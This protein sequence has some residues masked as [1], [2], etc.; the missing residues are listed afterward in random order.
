[1]RILITGAHGQLG[2]ELKRCLETMRAEIGPIPSEYEAADITYT[3]A[4]TLDIT[5]ARAVDAAIDAGNY[6]L[7]INCAAMTNVDG[8]E[9]AP[10][11][12]AR[13]NADAAEYLARAAARNNAKLVQV[14]TDYVFSGTEPG[15]RTETDTTGP[16][17]VYGKTKLA[18]E[19]AA[20][21]AND[22]TFVVRTAWLYGY[23][24]KNFVRTMAGLGKKL[25]RV[26]VVDDQLGNPTSANDLAYEILKIALTDNYGIYH[27]TNNGVCSWADLAEAVMDG[28]NL[29]CEVERCTSA[30]YKEMHPESADRP[31]YSALA[32]VHLEETIGDEMRN[33]Q[34]AL[35]MFLKNFA[36]LETDDER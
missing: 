18:G 15:E 34:D 8:C 28:L 19:A 14:S 5:D 10:D 25:D 4:D 22:K 27:C 11:A 3:D 33:W 16:I 32:N 30:Q 24:G 1:M 20:L 26:V 9:A 29:N 36:E 35:A 21:S 13:V 12:A 23:V 31:H 6:D 17:S 7:V 2:V